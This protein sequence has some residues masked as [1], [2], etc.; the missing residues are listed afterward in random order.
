M[1]MLIFRGDHHREAEGAD[2]WGKAAL[3]SR[4]GTPA[5]CSF[6]VRGWRFAPVISGAAVVLAVMRHETCGAYYA[7]AHL[8]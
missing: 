4:E 3:F 6:A 7:S 8:A 5:R 2:A 1:K